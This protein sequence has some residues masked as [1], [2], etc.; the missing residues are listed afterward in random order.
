MLLKRRRHGS[1]RPLAPVKLELLPGSAGIEVPQIVFKGDDNIW[2]TL[3]PETEA[4]V[5]ALMSEA[6]IV[7]HNWE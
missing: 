4:D 5:R 6:H 7:H 3:V 1:Q 2:Y